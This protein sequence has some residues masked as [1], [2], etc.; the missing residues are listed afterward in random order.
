[1][2][3]IERLEADI[4]SL[5]TKAVSFGLEGRPERAETCR[6]LADHIR[7]EARLMELVNVHRNPLAK[8]AGKS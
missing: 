2:T 5:R 3:L 6:V 1:M 8:S 4:I 7:M